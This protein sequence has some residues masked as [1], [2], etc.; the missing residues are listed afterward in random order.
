MTAGTAASRGG[1]P[2]AA[3]A[4]RLADDIVEVATAAFLRDGYAATS[5][6]SV[7]KQARVGKRTIYA[8]F[9][10]KEALFASVLERLMASWLAD[11]LPEP[12]PGRIETTLLGF[13]DRM[14]AIALQPQA[15]ALHRLLLAE[16]GRFRQIPALVRAAGTSAGL[17]RIAAVL[18]EAVAAGDLPE[19][20]VTFA[21]EQFMHLVLTGP[22]RRALG[23][24]PPLDRTER[25]D[26]A[27][28]SVAL[29]LHGCR[30]LGAPL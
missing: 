22:Q 15:L 29:F 18:R 5:I 23:V 20:D 28:R 19:I 11:P 13:A 8:R 12:T 3:A 21:A 4:A 27:R 16:S 9:A 14:L 1:R 26:W 2:T 30:G 6:E 25:A 7:A 10:D 17:A 24:G